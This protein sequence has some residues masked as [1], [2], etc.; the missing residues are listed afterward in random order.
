MKTPDILEIVHGE[1]DVPCRVVLN[2]DTSYDTVYKRTL[3]NS[4][5]GACKV[6]VTDGNLELGIPGNIIKS[7]TLQKK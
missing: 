3:V 2:D 6:C 5:S 7:I 1:K 4:I